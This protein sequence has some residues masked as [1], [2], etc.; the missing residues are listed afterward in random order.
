VHGNTEEPFYPEYNT[1]MITVAFI[2]YRKWAYRIFEN[3]KAFEKTHPFFSVDTIITTENR[4]F[5]RPSNYPDVKYIEVDGKDNGK[6][7]EILTER[8]VDI[9]C[10]YGWSWIVREP[11]LSDFTCLCLHPSPLPKYRGGT[12]IQHQIIHGEKH[13]AVTV[14]RMGKGI[15]DGDIYMQLPLSL[16]GSI[17]DIFGQ[18]V[19][20]GTRITK[21]FLTD[22]DKDTVR[23]TPQKDLDKNPPFKRRRPE[24]GVFSLGQLTHLTYPYMANCVRALST[25][26]P[27]LRIKME[28]TELSVQKIQKCLRPPSDARILHE[29]STNQKIENGKDPVYIRLKDGCA[30]LTGYTVEVR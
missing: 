12:P 17:D 15:D 29:G 20:Q 19:D 1:A 23:F 16:E 25:P 9:V 2:I 22:L 27:N 13:S 14:F 6:I 11:I 24:D 4:Q 10:F 5:D 7:H 18:M 8:K 30:K 21:R 3:I 28:G 26:Y